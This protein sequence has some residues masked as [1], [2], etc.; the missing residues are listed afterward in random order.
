MPQKP[1]STSRLEAFS[2]GV[3]AVIITIMVLELKVPHQEGIAGLRAI[4]PTLLVYLLSFTFTGI[5]WVN[6]DHLLKRI[7]IADK[8]TI[9]ANLLFLFWLSLLP[10]F[11]NYV[12]EK[13]EDA[14]SVVLY[15]LSMMLTASSFF[16]L[17]LAIVRQLRYFRE[18]QTE[19]TKGLRLHLA[20]L[21]IYL[22]AMLLARWHPYL[23]LVLTGLVAVPWILPN[24][25]IPDCP[26]ALAAGEPAVPEQ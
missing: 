17:R 3:M 8:T 14:F 16:L 24:L 6:H 11:T 18:L 20:T 2:D 5:Y 7:E 1:E 23:A 15:A 25:Q 13:K 26:P 12:L 22:V 10:F 19:D 4:L 21:G 9:Y